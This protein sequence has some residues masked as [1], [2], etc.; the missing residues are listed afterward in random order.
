MTRRLFPFMLCLA[1]TV[2]AV[3]VPDLQRFENCTL[4]AS[5]WADGD[6]FP[7]KI[8][9]GREEVVR[10][11]FVDCP[12]TSAGTESDQRRVRE[13]SAYFGVEDPKVTLE[14]GRKAKDEVARILSK[15]FTVQTAF[16]RALGRSAKPRIYAF[17][18]TSDGKDLAS[19][20]VEN[21]LA[22]S[23]GV[24][25]TSP[26]GLSD[27]D[28]KA[29]IDD[30]ELQAALEK[31]GLWAKTNPSKL[32][33]MREERREEK[34]ELEE[35]FGA[36]PGGMVDVNTASFEDVERL[37]GVGKTLAQRIIDGRPYATV[38]DV[39]RVYGLTSKKF[40]ALKPLLS[41]SP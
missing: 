7:V 38:D 8:G 36:Q 21:G 23:Y 14:F 35:E 1:A 24:G 17:V 29:R 2:R 3:P 9:P 34:R 31:K 16:S 12:E 26:E 40:E 10:L 39:Q 15:A 19:W 5:E 4:A 18:T 30:I 27:D 37:P 25:R 11:Y 20:L 32:A 28:A 41:V 13:Q 6:S 22:R 33:A